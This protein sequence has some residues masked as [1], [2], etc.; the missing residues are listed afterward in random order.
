MPR[1]GIVLDAS[2]ILALLFDEPGAEA[3]SA[4][5]AEPLFMSAVNAAE[6]VSK[7]IDAGQEPREAIEVFRSIQDAADLAAIPF[8]T[9]QA[10]D[11]AA[12]RAGTR[13]HGLSLGDRA[14]LALARSL[15]LPAMTADRTWK[16]LRLGVEIRA[17]R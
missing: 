11:A 12:I 15:K 8:D 7:L 6:V 16:K 10:L 4:R 2:A 3:V 13:D 14:C 1:S 5:H 17:I 9:S